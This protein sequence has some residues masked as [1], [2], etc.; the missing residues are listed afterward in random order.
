MRSEKSSS[1]GPEVSDP[2]VR[3]GRF[4]IEMT[5]GCQDAGSIPKVL[6]AG[7]VTKQDGQD[8]QIMHNGVRVV[9]GGY[10]GDWMREVIERLAGHHEPQEEAVFHE[11]MSN[12]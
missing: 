1:S 9:A 11:V 12:T 6:G 7:K 3:D 2:P 8:V 10:H 4:R 5:V